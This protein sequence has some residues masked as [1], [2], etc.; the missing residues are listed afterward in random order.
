MLRLSKTNF[1]KE[2]EFEQFQAVEFSLL[3][4]FKDTLDKCLPGLVQHWSREK[5][6]DLLRFLLDIIYLLTVSSWMQMA[7]DRLWWAERS[8]VLIRS[9]LLRSWMGPQIHEKNQITSPRL[10]LSLYKA[11]KL[12]SLTLE[13]ESLDIRITGFAWS[14][15]GYRKV[16]Y[17]RLSLGPFGSWCQYKMSTSY[18]SNKVSHHECVLSEFW[19]STSFPLHPG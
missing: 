2:W 10:S 5:D 7:T 13:C 16:L 12:G 17:K 4:T 8:T 6:R 11:R 18:H 19:I 1:L 15:L 14:R 3:K 9:C